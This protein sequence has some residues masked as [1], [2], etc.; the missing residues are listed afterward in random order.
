MK[1]RTISLIRNQAILLL[2]LFIILGTTSSCE[3]GVFCTKGKGELVTVTLDLP[4]L[5]GFDNASSADVVITQGEAQSVKVTAQQNIIDKMKRKVSNGTWSIDIDGCI[6]SHKD[7]LVEITLPKLEFAGISGSGTVTATHR[8]SE[9]GDV[10]LSIAGSGDMVL[11]MDATS[12]DAS[13]SG[14]GS[15]DMDLTA[16]SV[17]TSTSGSGDYKLSGTADDLN[18]NLTGSGKCRAFGLNAKTAEINVTGSGDCE[19][20]VSETLDVSITGSGD[21]FYKGQP[22]INV[23]ITGSGS[24]VNAN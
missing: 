15:I 3:R 16:T 8:L 21:V 17:Y 13:I 24:L 9:L 6:S 20:T 5:T 19:T 11:D 18:Y 23:D 7:I 12:I 4:A 2:A 1:T 10:S 14:S 22:V